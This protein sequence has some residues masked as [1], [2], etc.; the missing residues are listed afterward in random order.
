MN[1]T[2][3]TKIKVHGGEI[4]TGKQLMTYSLCEQLC[5]MTHAHTDNAFAHL[6]LVMEW[7]LMCRSKSVK[8]IH[9]SS[10]VALDDS[11][12]CVLHQTKI[13]R[14][15]FGP[16]SAHHIHVNP[17]NSLTCSVRAWSLFGVEP[18]P[19]CLAALSRKD[20]EVRFSK[21]LSSLLGITNGSKG[22]STHSIRKRVAIFSILLHSQCRWTVN[23][24][25]VFTM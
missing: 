6:F 20:Q 21:S 5:K 18:Q 7:T 4:L 19:W 12:N 10:L 23:N 13:N 9:I 24:Q 15:D 25:R 11:I 2:N 1:R 8:T 14:N 17:S 16:K 3:T 22:F